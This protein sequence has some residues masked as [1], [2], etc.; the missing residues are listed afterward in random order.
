M[1]G[2]PRRAPE[3]ASLVREG[4][5]IKL[6]REKGIEAV[7]KLPHKQNSPKPLFL[8]VEAVRLS[9]LFDISRGGK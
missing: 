2:G 6:S 9:R 8:S 3:K 1:A 5:S 4:E 7:C